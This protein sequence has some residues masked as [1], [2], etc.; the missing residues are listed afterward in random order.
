MKTHF[1]ESAD[2]KLAF[3][4]DTQLL[5]TRASI[6]SQSPGIAYTA[7]PT[8]P[9]GN[10]RKRPEDSERASRGIIASVTIEDEQLMF[11]GAGIVQ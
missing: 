11:E 5:P 8:S 4:W 1:L 10:P 7:S 2:W 3:R 6:L 9:E